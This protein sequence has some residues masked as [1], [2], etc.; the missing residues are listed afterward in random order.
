MFQRLR[1]TVHPTWHLTAACLGMVVGATTAF[2]WPHASDW[3]W[4]V[5]GMGVLALCIWKHRRYFVIIAFGAGAMIGLWRGSVDR[6]VVETYTALFGQH[7]KISGVIAEDVEL[8]HFGQMN[9]HL[10]ELRTDN[11]ALVGHVWVTTKSNVGLQRGDFITVD[12]KLT[13]GFGSFAASLNDARLVTVSRRSGGDPFL[14]VRD[15]VATNIRETISEPAASLGSGYLL[16][17]KNSLPS[18]LA[19]A[20]K[21]AGLTH[22]VVASGYNLTILVRLGRRLFEKIS[23][24]LAAMTGVALVLG[25]AGIAGLSPSMMRAGIVSL[26]ALWAWYV[27]RTFHPFTLLVIAA[28]ITV[29]IDPSYAWGNIGWELSFAAFG[30]VMLVAPLL[31]AYFFGTKRPGTIRQIVGESVAAQLMTAPIIGVMFGQFSVVAP[32]S[33]LLILP[34]V[35]LAM[36]LTAVAGIGPWVPGIGSFVGYPAQALLDTM[37]WFIHYFAALPW[38]QVSGVI[39]WWLVGV[40]YTVIAVGCWYMQR[41]TGYQLRKASVVE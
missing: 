40:W 19:E 30:G 21:I 35:P 2:W 3:Y 17:Q 7:I 32:L 38:A 16:G 37:I 14:V 24:Y 34:F 27:G 39:S 10:S 1:D 26:L 23:K 12:G 11:T 13:P 4:Y 36:L 28:A 29:M 25:F 31:Q 15:T 8:N 20:L 22:I 18:D 9:I 41:R 5:A 6:A 33:N